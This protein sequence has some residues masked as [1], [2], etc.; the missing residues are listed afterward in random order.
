MI[1]VASLSHSKSYDVIV[2]GAGGSGLAAAVS[3]AESGASVLVLESQQR[4]GGTSRMAV[5]SI[6]AAGTRLQKQ[7]GIIDNVQDFIAD[8]E[9]FTADLLAHDNAN[10]RQVLAEQAAPTVEWLS[11]MGVVFVGPYAESPHRV[12]R[13]HNAVPGA[14]S[15][16]ERLLIASQRLGVQIQTQAIVSELHQNADGRV[17]AVS[18]KSLDGMHRVSDRRAVILASGDFSAS[19]AM[20]SAHLP[21]EASRAIP[22]NPSNTG[23]MFDV[24]RKVG[25]QTLNMEHVLGPQMRFP[26]GTATYLANKMPSWPWL[27]RLTAVFFEYAPPALKKLLAKPMLMAHMSPSDQLF[28]QGAV[29][30]DE[31]G[32]L[33]DHQSPAK[34]IAMTALRRGFIVMPDHV[35]KKFNAPPY[36]ISTAPSIAYAFI[37]DYISSRPDIAFKAKDLETLATLMGLSHAKGLRAGLSGII[38]EYWV[39]LGPVQA[40]LTT[41]E[42][43]LAINSQC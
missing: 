7:A 10:L 24:S 40:M 26:V 28:A 19:K 32:Q 15:I 5:G 31:V 43:S 13:M 35:A 16:V 33:L 22:I 11:Q 42:G 14:A 37:D 34:A 29:L 30:V 6:S 27:N 41:T 1:E 17:H 2:V 39:G 23:E 9:L 18:F 20:R 25:A 8:M 12:E 21:L 4:P 38:A 3:A 36:F